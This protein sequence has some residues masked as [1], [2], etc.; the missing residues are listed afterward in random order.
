MLGQSGVERQYLAPETV[1][2]MRIIGIINLPLVNLTIE[3]QPTNPVGEKLRIYMKWIIVAKGW[4]VVNPVISHRSP[5]SNEAY[6]IRIISVRQF[7]D[8]NFF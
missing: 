6:M 3:E 7:S 2:V 5:F 8:I 1:V 4:I